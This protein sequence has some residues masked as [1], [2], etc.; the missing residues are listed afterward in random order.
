MV[1]IA[2]MGLPDG[3]K[4]WYD[5]FG[6]LIRPGQTVRW[7]NRDKGNSHT[8]TAYAGQDDD[9]PRRIPAAAKPFD[10]DYLLPGESFEVT[11]D[12]PGIY[13]FFCIPHELA[14][15]VGRIVVAAPGPVTFPD[16]PD[17]NL[18]PVILAGFPKVSD[19]VDHG[20]L[21]HQES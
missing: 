8:A 4:V 12:V 19:I 2:Q 14:G 18:D 5:P 1:E 7:T 17:G 10:S 21:H 16:Y 11:L 6:I 15:M 9:H 20:P 13:D 3:S